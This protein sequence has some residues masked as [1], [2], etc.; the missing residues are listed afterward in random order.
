MGKRG[1]LSSSRHVLLVSTLALL[2]A[3]ATAAAPASSA[4]AGTPCTFEYDAIASPG[5]SSSPSS[6]TVT[7]NGE[8][9]TATCNGPVNGK[10][11][12]G[13][14][15]IGSDGRY[16][17]KSG[18][19]CQSGGDGAGTTTFTIPTSSGDEHVT[20]RYTATFGGLKNGVFSG[21]YEGDRMSGTYDATPQ[22]G[23][24]VSRPVTKFH[25]KGKG[26]LTG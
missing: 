11:P 23:D 10:E 1:I 9:G 18:A 12:T 2:C 6:G 25:V 7:T 16:G 8:T 20:I 21:Q 17:I 22:D 14:G 13:P 19:T 24:C 3:S 26:T 5:L 4:A 15:K